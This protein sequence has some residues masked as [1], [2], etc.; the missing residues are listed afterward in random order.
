MFDRVI[1]CTVNFMFWYFF[2]LIVI[3]DI[4]YDIKLPFF[5]ETDQK[6]GG[7]IF[8]VKGNTFSI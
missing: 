4:D 2:L 5:S 3:Y 8:L 1:L 6:S 7:G